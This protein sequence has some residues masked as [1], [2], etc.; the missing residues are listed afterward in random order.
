MSYTG[1]AWEVARCFVRDKVLPALPPAGTP[2]SEILTLCSP[3]V[4]VLLEI[5]ERQILPGAHRPEV[6][7]EGNVEA[8]Q[9]EWKRIVAGQR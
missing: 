5:P 9:E 4:R 8:T 2:G 7:P 3:E 6:A 1:R